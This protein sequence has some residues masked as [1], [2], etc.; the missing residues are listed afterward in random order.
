MGISAIEDKLQ[1]DLEQT[2]ELLMK[3]NIKF[4]VLTGDK[5]ETAIEIAKSCWLIKE[6]FKI[7]TFRTNSVKL[8]NE[9]M[10]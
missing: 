1:E 8:S 5:I 4:W 3:A 2:I 7:I 9:E 6:D 10:V